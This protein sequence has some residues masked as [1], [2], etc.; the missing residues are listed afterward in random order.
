MVL[1]FALLIQI[2][3]LLL[4]LVGKQ[5]DL[6]ET[7]RLKI[8]KKNNETVI[9]ISLQQARS[10]NVI[11]GGA[12]KVW[13]G[14]GFAMISKSK[15]ER[16]L[17]KEELILLPNFSDDKKRSS[18]KKICPPAPPPG[19]VPGSQIPKFSVFGPTACSNFL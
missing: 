4:S 9:M 7:I 19:Y 6:L 5:R 18:Q 1:S 17:W 12:G 14:N 11:F 15:K 8:A 2:T 3:I 13:G 16:S 10:Q